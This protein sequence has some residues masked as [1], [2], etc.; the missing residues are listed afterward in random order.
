MRLSRE[1]SI[2][3]AVGEMILSPVMMVLDWA[4]ETFPLVVIAEGENLSRWEEGD[5]PGSA[6]VLS[7]LCLWKNPDG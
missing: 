5:F 6:I 3:D 4:T 2:E 1:P 7:W